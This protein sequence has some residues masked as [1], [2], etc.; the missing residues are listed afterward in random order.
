MGWCENTDT[1]PN[2]VASAGA[3]WQSAAGVSLFMPAE[4][5]PAE[6]SCFLCPPPHIAPKPRDVG[7]GPF[8]GREL[9]LSAWL[10]APRGMVCTGRCRQRAED[11]DVMAELVAQGAGSC[12]EQT[13]EKK[14][15]CIQAECVR[16]AP[17][18]ASVPRCSSHPILAHVPIQG[19][20]RGSCLL[21]YAEACSCS[22]GPR[23]CLLTWEG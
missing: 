16:S 5:L 11:G 20:T 10:R 12:L 9:E 7:F 21:I 23:P 3:N 6:P 14:L 17:R 2:A 8:P 15:T 4:G 1:P 18:Q 19:G 13:S 22:L